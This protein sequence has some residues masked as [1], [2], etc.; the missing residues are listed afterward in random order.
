MQETANRVVL[1]YPDI[2]FSDINDYYEPRY[3]ALRAQVFMRLTALYG[4]LPIMTVYFL[5]WV[6]VWV[7]KGFRNAPR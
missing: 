5:G 3:E 7:R 1:G 2:D 6:I 4:L